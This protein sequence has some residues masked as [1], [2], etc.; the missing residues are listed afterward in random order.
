[1]KQQFRETELGRER[2]CNKCRDYWP[3]DSE[4]FYLS[5]GE[6]AQPC[7]ACYHQLPSVIAKRE[8][9]ARRTGVSNG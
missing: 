6:P 9:A 3:D 8:R 2:L 7:K 1:M 4:F 5:K